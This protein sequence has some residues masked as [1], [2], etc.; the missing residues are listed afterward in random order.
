[1]ESLLSA[2][3]SD[4]SC[5]AMTVVVHGHSL[6]CLKSIG[7]LLLRVVPENRVD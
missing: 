6:G 1:M 7:G 4:G 2:S 3:F 5:P